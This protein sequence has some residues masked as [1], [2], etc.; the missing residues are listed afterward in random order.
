MEKFLAALGKKTRW[1][2]L[3]NPNNP[4]GTLISKKDLGTL[5]RAAPGTVVLV[6]EAYFDFSGETVLL[7]IRKF[8][9]LVVT[10]TFSKAFG[11]AALRLG[12]LFANAELADAIPR[13]QNPFAVTSLP[14]A[15]ATEATRHEYLVRRN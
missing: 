14:L 13:A 8:S 3:A 7:W 2:A 15:S 5:L 11:L 10:R 1:V 4:T 6:D 9:N 12:C